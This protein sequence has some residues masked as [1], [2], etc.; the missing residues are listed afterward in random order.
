MISS[1]MIGSNLRLAYGTYREK[2]DGPANTYQSVLY[3]LQKMLELAV[4][5]MMG[6]AG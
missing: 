2:L 5:T 6:N 4:K 3:V 1:Q